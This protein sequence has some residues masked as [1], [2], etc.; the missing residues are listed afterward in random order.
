LFYNVNYMKQISRHGTQ[1]I[2]RTVTIL[3][4]LGARGGMGWRLSDLAKSCELDRGTTHRIL[5]CLVRERLARQRGSD[6]RYV[7]G[8]LLFELGLSLSALASFQSACGAPLARAARR[9]NGVSL[10]CLRSGTEFVCAGRAGSLEIKA[11]TIDVGTRRPL[12]VSVGGVA[13]LIALP[14]EEARAI[15]TENLRQLARFGAARIRSLQRTIRE[16][17]SRGYGVS[18]SEIVPGV[19]AFGVPILDAHERPFASISIV[20][21]SENF[22]SPRIPEVITTVQREARSISREAVRILGSGD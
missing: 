14:K 13:I 12:I 3:K 5:A 7:P 22:P 9:L 19:S 10:L 11:L 8:P 4:E 18:Q 17:E 16:S 21:P 15:V 1:T 20:G 2:E 6:R